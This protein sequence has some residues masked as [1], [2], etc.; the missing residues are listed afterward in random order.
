MPCVSCMSLGFSR[1]KIQAKSKYYSTKISTSSIETVN[2]NIPTYYI[3]SES[4]RIPHRAP[5]PEKYVY[6]PG[7][8]DKAVAASAVPGYSERQAAIGPVVDMVQAA[9]ENFAKYGTY[10]VMTME[11]QPTLSKRELKKQRKAER[12]LEK[13]AM[14]ARRKHSRMSRGDLINAESRIGSTIFGPI[15]EGHRREFFHDQQNVWIWHEGWLD[16]YSHA[17]QFTVR[18]EVRPSGVYKKLSAGKYVQL[19]GEELDNFRHAARTYLDLVKRQLY[20][21]I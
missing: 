12:K 4:F 8:V 3:E 18:Y 7:V 16:S 17:H 21:R 15:P 6:M 11:T 14:K 2:A 19:K 13:A 20:A 1:Q 10:G 5:K 9:R